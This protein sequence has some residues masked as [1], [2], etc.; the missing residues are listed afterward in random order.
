MSTK[1]SMESIRIFR[2]LQ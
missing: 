1:K 2:S